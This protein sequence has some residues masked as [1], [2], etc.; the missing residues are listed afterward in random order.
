MVILLAAL[1]SRGDYSPPTSRPLGPPPVPDETPSPLFTAPP[2]ETADRPSNDAAHLRLFADE[3][4]RHAFSEAEAR[5]DKLWQLALVHIRLGNP[6]D[7]VDVLEIAAAQQPT[8]A[9]I[10]ADLGAAYYLRAARDRVAEDMF[11]SVDASARAV[12]L[13]PHA[14][15]PTHNLA[16]ALMKIGGPTAAQTVRQAADKTRNMAETQAA[17]NWPALQRLVQ[18]DPG[19]A[20]RY[21]EET[22]LAG[23]AAALRQDISRCQAWTDTAQRIGASLLAT[24]GD[25]LLADLATD[26]GDACRS[27]PLVAPR[28]AAALDLLARAR[29]LIDA[30]EMQAALNHL[31]ATAGIFRNTRALGPLTGLYRLAAR[32]PLEPSGLLESDVRVTTAAAGD[33]AHLYILGRLQLLSGTLALRKAARTEALEQYRSAVHTFKRSGDVEYTASTTALVA[34]SL[35]EQG[36]YAQ[37]WEWLAES[38]RLIDRVASPRRKLFV[39]YNAAATAIESGL[40]DLA[41]V[42]QQSL[43]DV[44]ADW[45][46]PTGWTSALSLQAELQ[47]RLGRATAARSALALARARAG[48]V[49]DARYRRQ[50]DLQIAFTQGVVGHREYPARS[51]AALSS[52]LGYFLEQGLQHRLPE[53]YLWRGR[54]Y[55][56]Q[57]RFDAAEA[58]WRRGIVVFESQRAQ[59]RDE[60][61]RISHLS[62]LWELYG[63]MI[64]LLAIRRH[65]PGEAFE[66]VERSRARAL[67]DSVAPGQLFDPGR[68]R[69]IAAA[70]P[71]NV[72]VVQYSSLTDVLLI[73]AFSRNGRLHAQVPVGRD[74]LASL[75][76]QFRHQIERGLPDAAT[77]TRLFALLLAPVGSALAGNQLVIVPDG[78]IGDLPFAALRNPANGH[79][80]VQDVAV[81]V[82][83]SVTL[84]GIASNRLDRM[85]R[86]TGAPLVV[87][88]PATGGPTISG[89]RQLPGSRLEAEEIAKLDPTSVLYLGPDA[90]RRRFLEKLPG[91]SMVHFSGHAVADS[92]FPSKSYLLL[93][94]DAGQVSGRLFPADIAALR[95]E[96]TQLA[97][98]SACSTA[99]G[100]IGLGEGVVNLA[101]PFL[102]AGVPQVVASL[103]DV[104]DAATRAILVAFHTRVKRGERVP[105]AL[106]V[107]Q[108][109][110]LNSARGMTGT[111]F[112]AAFVPIGGV[113]Q[114]H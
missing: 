55:A 14:T 104:D 34:Q 11:K 31:H 45:N 95:L 93:A 89:L 64:H 87:G 107:A 94:P 23:V 69:A 96:R 7:A 40:Y 32:F 41:L 58:D 113:S 15:K 99:S 90:T 63:E 66:F 30:G 81:G 110:L 67:L 57:G 8:H 1:L 98:L 27:T 79:R 12:R 68:M 88:D 28:F 38:L 92:R 36:D 26:I 22:V 52:A 85:L 71:Q 18:D 84:L 80:L 59:V 17:G 51:A 73:Q 78:A 6:T 25:R 72:A 16:L 103:W 44:A 29:L 101:R 102:I 3:L 19:A 42:L 4:E 50:L 33:S 43:L 47:D 86:A 105:D 10:A 97:V 111:R 20:R 5:P 2:D 24:T 46:D 13:A 48:Q 56:A 106:R 49:T 114:H 39:L 112:W 83:P 74:H 60:R 21:V 9:G 75:I 108:L 53:T 65:R 61:L 77:A 100:T 54:A 37:A 76:R 70:L 82:A 109:E 35:K 62:R 91:A